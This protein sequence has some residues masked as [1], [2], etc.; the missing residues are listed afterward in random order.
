MVQG[1]L[2]WD[3]RNPLPAQGP[4]DAAS[5]FRPS[6][7]FSV[8]CHSL[9]IFSCMK[10]RKLNSRGRHKSA[11]GCPVYIEYSRVYYLFGHT[12]LKTLLSVVRLNERHSHSWQRK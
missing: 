5:F 1:K 3:Q 6:P 10:D 7:V 9:Q 8:I 12:F 4:F 11:P 2:T